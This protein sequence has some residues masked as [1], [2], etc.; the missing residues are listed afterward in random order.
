MFRSPR[1]RLAV[2]TLFVLVLFAFGLG[3]ASA[4]TSGSVPKCVAALPTTVRNTGWVCLESYTYHGVTYR[5]GKPGFAAHLPPGSTL[6]TAGGAVVKST[7]SASNVVSPSVSYGWNGSQT[8]PYGWEDVEGDVITVGTVHLTEHVGF[9]GRQIQ[10]T[11]TL[12]VWAGP[13]LNPKAQATSGCGENSWG[14]WDEW[15][16]TW[17]PTTKT[18]YCSSDGLYHDN[19]SYQWEADPL[20]VPQYDG[21]WW[22]F[23]QAGKGQVWSDTWTCN[24]SWTSTGACRFNF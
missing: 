8:E 20:Q 6:A 21:Y 7:R 3:S 2:T 4:S 10:N 16:T 23:P 12:H 14:P 9:S 1:R 19:Y 22:V 15:V 17:L 24:A 11:V 18:V 13:N 5:Y